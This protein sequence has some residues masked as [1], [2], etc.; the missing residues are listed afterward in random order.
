MY[1]IKGLLLYT[2]WY[3]TFQLVSR[4]YWCKWENDDDDDDGAATKGKTCVHCITRDQKVRLSSLFPFF[5]FFFSF[6]ILFF[7]SFFLFFFPPI[8]RVAAA[9][10]VEP[11]WPTIIIHKR[12]TSHFSR[13]FFYFSFYFLPHSLLHYYFFQFSFSNLSLFFFLFQFFPPTI[14]HFIPQLLFHVYTKRLFQNIYYFYTP[15]IIFAHSLCLLLGHY[16]FYKLVT[17][18]GVSW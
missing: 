6:I 7:L 9:M 14:I 12:T 2:Y 11:H 4:I 16:Y 13:S 8:H 17:Q 3:N 1:N 15:Y 18:K 5:F 10:S